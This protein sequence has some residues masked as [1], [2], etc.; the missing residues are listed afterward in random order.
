M[1][2]KYIL[3]VTPGQQVTQQL[4]S[5]QNA[6]AVKVTNGTPFDLDY[7]GL[8]AQGLV[9][10]PAG[11]EYMFYAS[12]HVSGIVTILPVNN[13]N[14]PGTGVVNI[15]EYLI[16]ETLPQGTWPVTVPTQTVQA[17]VS[18]V[19]VLINDGS[20]L[21][22]QIIESTPAGAASSTISVLND[23]TVTIKG[24]VAAVLTTLLQLI[25]GAAAGASSVKLA[26]STRTTE[27]LGKAL[28]DGTLESVGAATFDSTST[29]TG[30]AD[31]SNIIK[32]LTAANQK[33]SS[34]GGTSLIDASNDVDLIFNAISG[35]VKS[36]SDFHGLGLIAP[37]KSA[38]RVNGTGGFFDN[39]T[40]IWGAGL[41]IY[42][43]IFVGYTN[44]AVA[45]FNF[46]SAYVNG[47]WCITPNVGATTT[48]SMF[49]GGVAQGIEI[50]APSTTG[51]GT[52]A[53]TT[54]MHGNDIGNFGGSPSQFQVSIVS[55]SFSGM[56]LAI[57]F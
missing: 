16:G 32:F 4:Q 26:D 23:G 10:V 2:Y 55:T 37:D 36:N 56:F 34:H 15:N 12:D 42:I 41:K 39:Y 24:D 57:G 20:S 35:S 28:V 9:I 7:S 17:K 40:P 3:T 48:F 43:A 21:G 31:F 29:H 50:I 45:S 30:E 46:P 11:L 22:T 27:V 1:S 5:A 38:T 49:A 8:G 18:T 13:N 52:G 25:P 19:T 6:Q 44:T 51:A 54:V 14:I 33:I 47:G 53:S